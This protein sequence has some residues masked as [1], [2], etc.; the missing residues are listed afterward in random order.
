MTELISLVV[1]SI[2]I[3][4]GA[5]LTLT[6]ATHLF[7]VRMGYTPLEATQLSLFFAFLIGSADPARKMADIFTSLQNACAAAAKAITA[8]F[9]LLLSLFPSVNHGVT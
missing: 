9:I 5:H 8:L 7:G 4:L 6:G 1:V 2:A 3:I